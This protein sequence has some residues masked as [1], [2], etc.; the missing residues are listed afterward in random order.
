MVIL[1]LGNTSIG[2]VM[3]LAVVVF[4]GELRIYLALVSARPASQPSNNTFQSYSTVQST[5]LSPS[6]YLTNPYNQ[7]MN[8]VYPQWEI[9]IHTTSS[10][11]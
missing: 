3:S 11:L 1:L 4:G 6:P 5:P 9:I 2:T 10:M 8:D 7:I